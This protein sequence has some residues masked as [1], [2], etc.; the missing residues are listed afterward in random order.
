MS[1]W[2]A[3]IQLAKGLALCRYFILATSSLQN[4]GIDPKPKFF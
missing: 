3:C 2:R 1:I 4:A